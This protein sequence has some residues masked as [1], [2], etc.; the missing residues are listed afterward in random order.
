MHHFSTRIFAHVCVCMCACATCGRHMQHI[1]VRFSVY[2]STSMR[3]SPCTCVRAHVCVRVFVRESRTLSVSRT[4]PPCS[5]EPPSFPL[6][7]SLPSSSSAHHLLWRET[8]PQSG[9]HSVLQYSSGKVLVLLLP[10]NTLYPLYRQNAIVFS[11]SLTIRRRCVA[12]AH[13][14]THTQ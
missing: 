6:R 5:V 12:R 2:P 13:T 8:P 3:Q 4:P 1:H 9:K 14:H 11:L 10:I 7:S